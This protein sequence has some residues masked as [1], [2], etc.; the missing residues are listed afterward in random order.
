MAVAIKKGMKRHPGNK[1]S[2]NRGTNAGSSSAQAAKY[3]KMTRDFI[4]SAAHEFRTP[5]TSIMGFSELLLSQQQAVELQTDEHQV[6]LGYILE[7]AKKLQGIVD[8]LLDLDCFHSGQGINLNKSV[9]RIENVVVETLFP[10]H[11]ERGR[12]YLLRLSK[13]ETV[14]SIDRKKIQLVLKELLQNAFKFS[15]ESPVCI[16]GC[17]VGE[18][19]QLCVEDEGEGMTCEQVESVFEPFYRAD[20][21]NT[22][23]EGLGLGLTWAKGIV[24]AHGGTI[25]V[26]SEPG[27]GTRVN[28]SLPLG[29]VESF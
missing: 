20:S 21:S 1:P 2:Q 5:L 18:C 12:R 6:Y 17:L 7:N 29:F 26:Q 4:S 13:G 10:F 16:Y 23:P 28:V 24:E 11:E 15:Y 8:T 25:R 27:W 3:E 14:V 9:C 22:S 19:Y